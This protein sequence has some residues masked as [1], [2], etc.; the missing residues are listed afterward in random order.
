MISKRTLEQI[1]RDDGR[2]HPQAVRFVFEGL[3]YT[4]KKLGNEPGHIAGQHLCD[5]LKQAAVDKW[6]R[7]AMLVLD[8][9]NVRTTRDLG[10]IVYLMIDHKWMRAQETDTIEDFDGVFD[11]EDVFKRDFTF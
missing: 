4:M 6:G 9:W 1:A 8:S 3:N 11:F 2:Y 10:E 5:G 7:L